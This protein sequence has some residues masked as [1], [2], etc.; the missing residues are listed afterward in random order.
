MIAPPGDSAGASVF[1]RVGPEVAWEVFTQEI[2][3]WW[4]TGPRFRIAGKRRGALRFEPRLGGA[5]TETWEE[6][7]GPR[8]H[9]VGR[10]L[11]WEPPARL[12]LEWRGVNFRP[13]ERT[14][15]EVRFEPAP[16]G[17]LVRVRHTALASLPPDH[18]ARHGLQGAD[19]CR[20]I[21]TWWGDLLRGLALRLHTGWSAGGDG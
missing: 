12:T 5:L 14:L 21:G 15:V 9:E 3:L 2:D 11:A 6:P 4:R 10:V 8:T 17:T 7:L 16:G 18:P 1:V 20:M 13:G 19:F